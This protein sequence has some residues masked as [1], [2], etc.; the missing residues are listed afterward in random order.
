MPSRPSDLGAGARHA[1]ARGC[2]FLLSRQDAG[3]SW[4]DYELEPGSS[5]AWITAYAGLSLLRDR[6]SSRQADHAIRR[7]AAAIWRLRQP[8]GWGYNAR[9]AVDADSSAWCIR[10][11]AASTS[12]GDLD[13]EGVLA[14]FLTDSGAARTFISSDRFGSWAAQHAEVTPAV[15]LA[16]LAAAA[17]RPSIARVR[18]AVLDA[19]SADCGWPAFWW[20]TP[21]YAIARNLAFLAQSGG[22][23]AHIADQ[24]TGRLSRQAAPDS[25][26]ECAESLAIARHVHSGR[27]T[28]LLAALLDMQ[29]PQGSWPPSRVLCVPAQHDRALRTVHDDCRRIFGTA[30]ALNA[31]RLCL[32]AAA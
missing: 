25:A 15:G 10:M 14:P 11:L 21:A 8:G 1:A 29:E 32:D 18:R 5:D 30:T 23:P 24:E 12:R 13:A 16:L 9:T 19:H 2:A 3:G 22:I 4:H 28:A 7:A 26:F 17:G 20:T 6:A 31:I 27:A